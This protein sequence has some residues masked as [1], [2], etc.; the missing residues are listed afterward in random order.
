M[1]SYHIVV[2]TPEGEETRGK[3]SNI[4]ELFKLLTPKEIKNV[5]LADAFK[6][7]EKLFENKEIKKSEESCFGHVNNLSINFISNG[8]EI[9]T[10]V[11]NF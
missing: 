1:S 6:G 9:T 3:A 8:Y 4:D 2:V 7:I 10:L 11:F 5:F